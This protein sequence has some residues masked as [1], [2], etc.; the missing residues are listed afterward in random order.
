MFLSAAIPGRGAS[1][2]AD[3]EPGKRNRASTNVAAQEGPWAGMHVRTQR[4][5]TMIALGAGHAK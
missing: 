2:A 4:E 3:L 5:L 1:L